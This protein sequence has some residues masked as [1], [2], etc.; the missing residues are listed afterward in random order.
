MMDWTDRHDRYFLRLITNHTR[1]Y[2]EM[3]TTQAIM[4]G[5]RE[6]LLNFNP[7]EHPLALQLGGSDPNEM[8]EC[9]RIAEGWGY[10]EV[11]I[12]IGCPSDRVQA[13][14]FGACLMKEM[15]LVA[16]CVETMRNTVSIPI[17]IKCRI[18]VDEQNP[19]EILPHF[20]ACIASSGCEV[21]IIHARKALLSGLSPSEN[22]DIPPLQY[23]LVHQIKLDRPDLTIVLNGGLR[24]VNEGQAHLSNVDGVMLGRAAY[25]TPWILSK[26]DS[27]VFL[28]DSGSKN[29]EEVIESMVDYIGRRMRE[30]VPLK[31]I[32]RHMM[33]LFHGEP[34]ARSWRRVLSEEARLSS[35]DANL[36]WK[37]ASF[38]N[39][40]SQIKN[41]G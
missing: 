21:F 6:K 2:T 9:A 3:L 24:S 20:I 22:R 4:F 5:D 37:A 39:S 30:G 38:I 23:P 10:D 26:V 41:R 35:A 40:K 8:A 31:S 11:N 17:T 29:R 28:D 14:R 13:G 33:G 12:N 25:Q 1:L 36:L 27:D 19:D 34:G 7:L 32:T 15:D 16:K 18:G